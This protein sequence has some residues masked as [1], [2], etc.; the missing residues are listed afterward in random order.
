MVSKD[1]QQDGGRRFAFNVVDAISI[2]ATVAC[3]LFAGQAKTTAGKWT[4]IISGCTGIG[5]LT[6]LYKNRPEKAKS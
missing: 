5:L 6:G 1:G 4:A 3:V 2:G